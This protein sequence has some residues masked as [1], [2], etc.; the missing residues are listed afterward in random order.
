MLVGFPAAQT[1]LGFDGHPS[2]IYMRARTDQVAAVDSVL[3]ATANPEN[4]SDV[5][6]SQPSAA[7]LEWP[8]SWSSPSSN[9]AEKNNDA[10][11]PDVTRARLHE[12][13]LEEEL[14]RVI[15]A[16]RAGMDPALA[17]GQTRE[18]QASIATREVGHRAMG[19]IA[20]TGRPAHRSRC[21]D[22]AWSGRRP[23][24]TAADRRSRG[25]RSCGFRPQWFRPLPDDL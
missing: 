17:A 18:I 20:R 3:A 4:P 6:V 16:I 22:R 8:T 23:H 21:T 7:P 12:R 5:N 25:A 13:R 9:D 10:E 11:P 15:A 1:Y 2:T 24:S 14:N 19:A